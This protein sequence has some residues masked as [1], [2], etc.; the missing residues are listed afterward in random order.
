VTDRL[1]CVVLAAAI[2]G[3]IWPAETHDIQ[4]RVVSAQ[5]GEPIARAR[6]LLRSY[7]QG[8]SVELALLSDADGTFH[9]ANVPDGGYQITCDKAGYL[10]AYEGVMV[11]ATG[12]A[13][14]APV[15]VRLTSQAVIEGTVVDDRGAPVPQASV[16][17][18]RQAVFNGRRQFQWAAGESTD[19]TGS[20]RL[21]GLPAGRYFLGVVANVRGAGRAKR[22]AYP[23]YFYP[24]ATDIA[25]AQGFDLQAGQDQPIQM[26]LPQ[27]LPAREIRGQVVTA[28]KYVNLQLTQLPSGN[29]F[30]MSPADATSF[31]D[32]TGTFKISGVT[33]GVYNLEAGTQIETQRLRASTVVTVGDTDVTGIRLE[34][35]DIVLNGTVRVEA[36][37]APPPQPRTP[38]S[39]G[40]APLMGFISI[41]SARASAGS[42][43]DKDGNFHIHSALPD[44]YHVV[45]QPFNNQCVRTIL[46]GGRD[47]LHDG[48]VIPP[49][50][51]PEPVDVLLTSHCGSIEGAVTLPDPGAPTILTVAL[52]RQIGEELVMDKQINVS[53]APRGNRMIGDFNGGAFGPRFT[54][55]GVTPGDYFLYAWPATAQVEYANPAYMQQFESARQT[56]T[57]TADN[58]ITVTID[59][60]LG[61]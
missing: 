7:Q 6:V 55:Q 14:P 23:V 13:K 58:K 49:E 20:F 4:G 56:V 43:V 53:S 9:V 33:A 59:R 16:Q 27:P 48:V 25:G 17:V 18:L 54:I 47:A 44:T 10:P 28:G 12:D 8:Q 46:Q 57:V 45:L 61:N 11:T 32:K 50:G 51:Q 40:P 1:R 15:E 36:D 52:L 38:A 26:R 19:E 3:T 22:L 41:Q 29:G 37:S 21:F 34:P 39:P 35:V 30:T 2:C 5:T 42:Q 24:N 31:V 60:I